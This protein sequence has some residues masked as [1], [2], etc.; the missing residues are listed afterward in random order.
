MKATQAPMAGP[1]I[2]SGSREPRT[3]QRGGSVTEASAPRAGGVMRWE[4]KDHRDG[5]PF[6]RDAAYGRAGYGVI[7][8]DL[9]QKGARLEGAGEG[10]RG[11]HEC[12]AGGW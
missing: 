7:G 10:L 2:G 12:H 11:R 4:G 6:V 5:E 8:N 1:T 3:R 9:A